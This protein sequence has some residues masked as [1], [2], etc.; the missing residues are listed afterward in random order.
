[1]NRIEKTVDLH[2][3]G[4]LT[5]SQ[6]II[7]AFGEQFGIS[8]ASAKA[9]GRPWSG[10]IGHQ[11]LTCGYLAG[12]VIVIAS[13]FDNENEGQARM[14]TDVAVKELFSRFE[15]RYGTTLCRDLL[16][17][18]MT[19]EAGLV[20]IMQE[21][22]VKKYCLAEDGIGQTVAEILDELVRCD[23]SKTGKAGRI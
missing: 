8:P 21:K 9:L 13:A 14:E 16:G 1:M 19:T 22:L 2:R 7:T 6:A 10:G 15:A 20:R 11:G 4:N 23:L 18:D 5:C 3:N 17:A 12:A